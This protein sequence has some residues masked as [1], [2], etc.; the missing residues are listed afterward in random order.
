MYI[1]QLSYNN[2]NEYYYYGYDAYNLKHQEIDGYYIRIYDKETG[3][4]VESA[5][6]VMPYLSLLPQA[7]KD[8]RNTTSYFEN[9][10]FFSAISE[11]DLN[12]LSL[13]Y[14]DKAD[15]VRM[16]NLMIEQDLQPEGKYTHI[17]ANNLMQSVTLNGYKWQAAYLCRHGNILAFRIELI[18]DDGT[19]EVYLSDLVADG[20]ATDEQKTIYDKYKQIE[21][22][23]LKTGSLV[24]AQT[25]STETIGD[26]SFS[27]L[28]D[29]LNKLETGE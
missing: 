27:T 10:K 17:P 15:V 19:Q 18:Y 9:K 2:D 28:F 3:E 11:S 4:E 14:I 8:I 23:V 29:L 26:I 5:T 20:K 1:S 6:A 25:D 12:D 16:Y 24:P 21:N 13:D 22:E 7:E